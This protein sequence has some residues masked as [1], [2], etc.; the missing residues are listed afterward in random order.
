MASAKMHQQAQAVCDESVD[1]VFPMSDRP[2]FT[3]AMYGVMIL[4]VIMVKNFL[5]V[6]V[7]VGLAAGA[8]GM[9]TTWR[10][11]ARTPT[12]I[13]VLKCARFTARPVA[14][15]SVVAKSDFGP[16]EQGPLNPKVRLGSTVWTVP[17]RWA[18]D[19]RAVLA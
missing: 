4:I 6:A 14:V 13:V 19:L 17:R 2:L 1:A 10:L 18:K 11:V 7:G 9:L 15:D 12:R 5:V 16:I 3:W 8:I